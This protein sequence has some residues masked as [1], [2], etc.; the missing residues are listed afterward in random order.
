MTETTER[1]LTYYLP[2]STSSLVNR[3]AKQ[4]KN[5]RLLMDKFVPANVIDQDRFEDKSERGR[6]LQALVRDNQPDEG[7]A[8]AS[9]QRWLNLTAATGAHTTQGTID[10]RM[11]VGLGGN[12]ILETDITLHHLYGTPI[13]P[14]SALKGLTRAYAATKPEF[15]VPSKGKEGKARHGQDIK[16]DT[17]ISPDDTRD[18]PDL[19]EIFGHAGEGSSSGSAGTVIFFD[20][21]PV[22]GAARL[23]VDIM[24]PHYPK[25]YQSLGSPDPKKPTNDQ[26]PIPVMFLTVPESTFAFAVAPRNPHDKTH[27]AHAQKVIKWL[28]QALNDQGAGGKT[29]AGYGYFRDFKQIEKPKPVERIKSNIKIPTIG[30]EVQAKAIENTQN[31][32]RQIKESESSL[33]FLYLDYP[34]KDAILVVK[35]ENSSGR[36]WAPGNS[37]NLRVLN[38]EQ[39]DDCLVIYCQA[40]PKKNIDKEKKKK[41]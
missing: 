4:T 18:H 10:W 37:V 23:E 12:N 1:T 16:Q 13:I 9:Y 7:L 19:K 35:Q 14:G 24:N 36:S 40:P 38:L 30:Q 5:M 8:K 32:R 11:V 17:M 41:R 26:N 25:Y 34:A 22:D 27:Q 21:V 29:S 31:L 28:E 33:L 6:W 20:A 2:G 39:I 15:R 3:H